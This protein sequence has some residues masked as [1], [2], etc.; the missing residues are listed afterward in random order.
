MHVVIFPSEGFFGGSQS[1]VAVNS[2]LPFPAASQTHLTSGIQGC[3]IRIEI[4][5]KFKTL[6]TR[7]RIFLNPQQCYRIKQFPLWRADSKI[8]GFACEFAECM[9]TIA[10]S[11]K[12]K[13]RIKKYPDTC[14]RGLS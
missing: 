7:I 1:S 4:L 13:L 10:V 14:G 9:R 12:K 5:Q 3:Y 8:S 6:S 2:Q 11:G